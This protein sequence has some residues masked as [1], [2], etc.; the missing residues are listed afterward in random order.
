ME[1]GTVKVDQQ[2]KQYDFVIKGAKIFANANDLSRLSK[3]LQSRFRRLFLPKYTEE[4][5][6]SVAIK[7][8]P[9][10]NE[11]LARY[12]GTTVF[13]NGGDVRDVLSIGK[14]IKRQDGPREVDGIIKT[15]LKY[16]KEELS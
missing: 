9:R 3:P 8:L 1:S 4:A 2:K 15:L 12:I 5:F 6:I 14:L 13:K 7:V 11:N 10:I 16:G